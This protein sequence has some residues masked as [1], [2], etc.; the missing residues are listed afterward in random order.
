MAAIKMPELNIPESMKN[1]ELS[2][3]PKVEEV[4]ETKLNMDSFDLEGKELNLE[5]TI[6]AA[7]SAQGIEIPKEE[8]SKTEE[9]QEESSETDVD[10]KEIKAH[11]ISEELEEPDFLSG[12][13]KDIKVA[14]PK[15]DEEPK[16]EIP[17]QP[18]IEEEAEEDEVTEEDLRRAEEEFLHGPMGNTDLNPE[19]DTEG[20][21]EAKPLT[22]EEELER[23]IE[24]IQPENGADPRDI[25]P[26]EKELTDDEKQLFT[27]FVKVPGMKEQLVDTL[28]DVQMAAADK[29]SKTGN[30]IVMG[31][32]ECG[33]TRLISG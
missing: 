18:E 5:D 11:D 19:D 29:T 4:A 30:I 23:F 24:S 21:E 8:E 10:D 32:K 27:Y 12:D 3:P 17:V 6:L 16:K 7:A 33:K 31:G 26:R 25:V 22:E 14:D 15:P 2:K 1:M 9:V 28:Y 13:I 20:T